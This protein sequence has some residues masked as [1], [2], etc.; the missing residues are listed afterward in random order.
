MS[1]LRAYGYPKNNGT[2]LTAG[3]GSVIG[4]GRKVNCTRIRPG[5]PGSHLSNERCSYQFK[6][7]GLW[8]ACRGMGD[9]MA[10]SCRV[11]KRAPA[12][13]RGRNTSKWWDRLDLEGARRRRRRRR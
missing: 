11:M 6:I 3:D 8:Y 12:D 13:T 10:A 2:L 1:V 7:K 9:G 4:K 5:A